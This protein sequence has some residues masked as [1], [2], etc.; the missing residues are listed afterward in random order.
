MGRPQWHA[1]KRE[2]GWTR[3]GG[4]DRRREGTESRTTETVGEAA[5]G[6]SRTPG[7]TPREERD[8][9]MWGADLGWLREVICN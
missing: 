5:G 2:G 8:V 9:T 6:Q 7:C 4:G 3:C 1:G